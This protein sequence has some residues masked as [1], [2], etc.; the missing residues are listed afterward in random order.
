MILTSNLPFGQ[1]GQ[2]FACDSALPISKSN[3]PAENYPE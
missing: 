3:P 1:W 2:T